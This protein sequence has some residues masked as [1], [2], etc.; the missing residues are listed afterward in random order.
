M[1]RLSASPTGS[2]QEHVAGDSGLPSDK[3]SGTSVL[4]ILSGGSRVCCCADGSEPGI[5]MG[6]FDFGDAVFASSTSVDFESA[7][8]GSLLPV[9]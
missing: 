9:G 5:P 6:S 8:S 1:A 3:L 4:D 2:G 7:G